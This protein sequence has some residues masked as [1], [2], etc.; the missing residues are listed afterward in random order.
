VFNWGKPLSL[1]KWNYT[2]EVWPYNLIREYNWPD[3]VYDKSLDNFPYNPYEQVLTAK[4]DDFSWLA[5]SIKI[6]GNSMDT[7]SLLSYTLR[8]WD[9]INT[10][11]WSTVDLY[12]SDWTV[13]TL[14][15]MSNASE[16]AFSDM[17]FSWDTNL[18]T[19]IKLVLWAWTIWNKATSLSPKSSFEIYTTDSSAAVRWT[20]FWLSKKTTNTTISVE[21]W[22][23]DVQ[24]VDSTQFS[25]ALALNNAIRARH[26][27]ISPSWSTPVNV[28]SWN[29]VSPTTNYIWVPWISSIT[30]SV[31]KSTLDTIWKFKHAIRLN[32][33]SYRKTN[34][35]INI[36]IKLNKILQNKAEYL[37][38]RASDINYKL[39]NNWKTLNRLTLTWG[40]ILS[41]ITLTPIAWVNPTLTPIAWVNPTLA[42]IISGKSKIK[43]SFCKILNSWEEKCTKEKEL[44][45]INW[46]YTR[47]DTRECP[48]WKEKFN[49]EC[50]AKPTWDL[51]GWELKAYAPY[52]NW[53]L[54]IYDKEW[55]TGAILSANVNVNASPTWILVWAW[56]Y[57]SYSWSKLQDLWSRFAIEMGVKYSDINTT[58]KFLFDTNN[59]GPFLENYSN[60]GLVLWE[61][62]NHTF[63]RL[64]KSDINCV[65]GNCKIIS[66]F[67]KKIWKIN[68]NSTNLILRLPPILNWINN[69]YI[70]SKK[71]KTYQWNWVI[72]Y[73]K[74]YKK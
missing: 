8:K 9:T 29:T 36:K 61:N 19:K 34:S 13:S 65:N 42:T 28:L 54:N 17:W 18:L 49:H 70:W 26:S 68:T 11:T 72:N 5:S 50:I 67:N 40:T 35:N 39:N 15:D 38:I 56:E 3:F 43:L 6:N 64:N 23:V 57:L 45:L 4:I 30:N 46:R 47:A 37:K 69:L 62:P 25:S 16:L 52:N 14:W 10:A 1:V 12:F 21:Q 33:L 22:N 71:N 27:V 73:V 53:D 2:A 48:H 55:N 60:N 7:G 74:I 44:K 41:N 63:Q 31:N 66:F 32:I 20:I 58:T 24:K 51:D 59:N